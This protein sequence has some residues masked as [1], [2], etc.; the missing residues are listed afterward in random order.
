MTTV[1]GV[2]YLLLFCFTS[3]HF[4][5]ATYNIEKENNV[6][7]NLGR[8]KR[9]LVS[10]NRESGAYII[11]PIIKGRKIIHSV[12][13]QTIRYSE[14]INDGTQLPIHIPPKKP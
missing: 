10:H 8:E 7:I 4:L 2:G 14:S 5:Y 13:Y 11:T 12:I 3:M 9:C 6:S 1:K